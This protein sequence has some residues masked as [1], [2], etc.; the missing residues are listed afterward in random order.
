MNRFCR[1]RLAASLYL[2]CTGL[3]PGVARPA[4]APA[5]E[6]VS[7]S[8]SAEQL[9]QTALRV[10]DLWW[11]PGESGIHLQAGI[12]IQND[13]PGC[14]RRE[15]DPGV[16]EE[17]S[18]NMFLRKELEI[19][20]PPPRHAQLAFIAREQYGNDADLEFTINGNVV[21]RRPTRLWAPDAR[22]YFQPDGGA[23]PAFAWSR[24]QY[25]DIPGEYLRTGKNTILIRSREGKPGWA[26]M[27]ADYADFHKGC[28]PLLPFPKGSAKSEDGGQTWRQDNLGSKGR[29]S[30]EYVLR[31]A[32]GSYRPAGELSSDIVDLGGEAATFKTL[33]EVQA[34]HIRLQAKAGPAT[35]L[36]IEVRSGDTPVYD[37]QHWTAFAH[38]AADGAVPSLRG[39]YLQWHVRFTSSAPEASPE[40][41]GLQIEAVTRPRSLGKTRVI[42]E[43]NFELG[44]AP[45][46]YRYEDYQSSYLQEFRRAFR[47]DDVVAGA[48]TEWERQLRLMRWAYL[49][50]LRPDPQKPIFPWDPLRWVDRERLGASPLANAWPERRRD[51]MCLFSN[52]TLV[53]AL[54]SFGYPARHLNMAAE[55]VSGHEIAEVW[56]N[57]FGKWI[58]LD[59]TLDLFWYDKGTGNPV[60][61]LEIHQ[62]LA[63]RLERT[64]TWEHPFYYVQRPE[65]YLLNFPI[66]PAESFQPRPVPQATKDWTVMATAQLRIVPRGDVFSH[67]AP[68][69]VSQGD[70]VWCWDGYLNWADAKVPPLP[71]FSR[72]TNREADFNWPLNQVR[73][74]AEET[75]TP[76]VVN[77]TL[78]H[79]M[80]FLAALQARIDHGPWRE[81]PKRFPWSLH[82]GVNTLE[83]RGRNTAGVEGMT[84]GLVLERNDGR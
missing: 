32:L 50:P 56:S 57:Q 63:D 38:V 84:S 51:A 82:A 1:L 22:Q 77:V 62:A 5:G 64:E 67:P 34:A 20:S 18:G 61:T 83:L 53:A 35:G 16:F 2:V 60:N 55:G 7:I 71:H 70:E 40:L 41:E 42:R 31:I 15:D 81:V 76:G 37:P 39:R 30:G 36:D 72:H 3:A 52:V 73:Y 21:V 48:H 23:A 27:V 25:Q 19:S 66:A 10:H 68:V 4:P 26:L 69:P 58:H 14:G 47:L 79:N 29:I 13:S 49:V 54:L 80:P 74:V 9:Y 43:D 44:A 75:A 65:T 33:R 8:L 6:A 12:V 46:G 17:I 28:V 11:Q 45:E 78:D 59:A 24:W